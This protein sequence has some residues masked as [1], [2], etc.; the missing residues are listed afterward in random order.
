MVRDAIDCFLLGWKPELEIQIGRAEKFKKIAGR[1]IREERN[2][3]ARNELRR[4][5][6]QHSLAQE[7]EK[8]SY[9]NRD[10]A[11]PNRINLAR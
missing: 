6:R 10:F 5:N 9:N 11:K 8:I 7:V 3:T 4:E 1:A 2:L